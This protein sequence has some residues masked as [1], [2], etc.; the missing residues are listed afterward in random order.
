MMLQAVGGMAGP[1]LLRF[2][3]H[4][5]WLW[6]AL[7]QF[8]GVMDHTGYNFGYVPPRTRA[9]ARAA[10]SGRTVFDELCSAGPGATPKCGALVLGTRGDTGTFE[11]TTS[12]SI[13]ANSPQSRPFGGMTTFHDQHHQHFH[14][15]YASCFAVIDDLFGTRYPAAAAGRRQP[16]GNLKG[17]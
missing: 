5:L 13:G 8:Q 11:F 15:N 14:Y 4:E 17:A 6:F 1:L 10:L 12:A 16:K 7:R 3:L 9:L 2:T